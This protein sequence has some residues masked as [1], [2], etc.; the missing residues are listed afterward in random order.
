[1]SSI[2]ALEFSGQAVFDRR[3]PERLT[4]KANGVDGHDRGQQ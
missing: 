1:M 4:F 3:S 2:L